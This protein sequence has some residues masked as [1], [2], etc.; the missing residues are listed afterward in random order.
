[1]TAISSF[2]NKI[3]P[4]V[5]GCP[6]P[7][8]DVAVV[9]AM[10]TFCKDTN[11]FT[12]TIGATGTTPSGGFPFVFPIVLEE[13]VSGD[14]YIASIDL[15]EYDSLDNY[16]PVMPVYFAEEGIEK[17]LLYFQLDNSVEDLDRVRPTNTR[18][19]YFLDSDTLKIFPYSTSGESEVTM[20]ITLAVEPEAGVTTVDDKFFNEWQQ[21]I[22]S[23]A[24]ATLLIAPKREWTDLA[25]AQIQYGIYD[26]QKSEVNFSRA[27]YFRKTRSSGGYI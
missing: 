15:S 2:R 22:V 26:K 20:L 14:F 12:R 19:Y 6:V 21:A 25:Q 7:A 1:M 8:I 17:N 3:L 23:L 11:A 13:S 4:Y 10:R 27:S 24:A 18:F 9:D 5:P 16:D